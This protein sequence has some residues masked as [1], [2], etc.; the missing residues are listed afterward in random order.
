MSRILSGGGV[1]PIAYWDTL[2]PP[3]GVNPPPG[4]EADPPPA[5]CMLGDEGNK[6]AVR[7]LLECILVV[8]VIIKQLVVVGINE[9]GTV[10]ADLYFAESPRNNIR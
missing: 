8:I 5:H 6:R 10:S 7:I 4:P 1:L 2:P 9:I 3:P